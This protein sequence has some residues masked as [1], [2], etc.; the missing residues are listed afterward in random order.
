MKKIVLLLSFICGMNLYAQDTISLLF[1]GDA[2]CHVPQYQWAYN[3]TDQTYDFAP[4]FRYIKPY[5]EQSDLALVNLETTLA[6]LPYSGYPNFATPDEYLRD[7]KGAGFDVMFLAN[8]HILDRGKR[9]TERTLEMLGTTPSAGAY[10]DSADRANRYPLIMEVQGLRIAFFNTTYG[11]NGYMPIAPNIVNFNDT[12]R[13]AQDL[14]AIQDSAIDLRVIYIHWGIEYQLQAVKEQE[15]LA[16]WL[17]GKGFD[18]I[19]GGHPHVIENA[20]YIGD[21]P[22]YYSLGNMIS[23][24]RWENCNGGILVRVNIDKANRRIISTE[25][26]PCYVHKGNLVRREG[27]EIIKERQYFIIPTTDY[28][29]GKYNF[30]LAPEDEQALK[31]FYHLTTE[32]LSNMTLLK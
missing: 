12:N 13:I 18:L 21:I 1:G 7:L 25:Y 19:I 32:R 8:N 5:I 14:A 4:C 20:G 9:G 10:R 15:T 16:K 24:Q 26:L 6:G 3:P 29:A 17:A 11:C 22:V 28:L 31:K 27:D 2:M 23:N 30:K